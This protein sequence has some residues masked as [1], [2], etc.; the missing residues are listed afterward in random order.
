M[1]KKDNLQ[2]LFGI[3]P[4]AEL[5]R[6]KKRKIDSIYT[7]TPVPKQ[8]NYIQSLLPSY[9]ITIKHVTRDALSKL[10]GSTDH[11]GIVA[12]AQPFV[13]YGK[14]FEPEKHPSLVVLDGIQDSRNLGAIIRSASCTNTVGV[15]I[16]QKNSSPL[17]A[18]ALKASAGLAEHILVRYVPSAEIA[19]EELR[20]AGYQIY[21][22]IF[23]GTDARTVA[24]KKPYA[25]VIGS[26]GSGISQPLKRHGI[27][28]TLPQ[29]TQDISYNA[30]VAAGLLMFLIA[31]QHGQI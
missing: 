30:S 24:F 7:T 6:A 2:L 19:A 28:L 29:R 18:I 12:F 14:P 15:L 9:P 11:Q 23:G 8:W 26:E 25:L 13:F 27:A 1:V 4:V 5:L 3:H 22:G 21:C 31:S 20:A 16:T 10:A 17:N